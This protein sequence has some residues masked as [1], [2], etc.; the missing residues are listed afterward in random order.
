MKLLKFNDRFDTVDKI[1]GKYLP[2]RNGWTIDVL[3]NETTII[4]N[5]IESYP[6]IGQ[7][8]TK[9]HL[10]VDTHLGKKDVILLFRKR[11]NTLAILI[12]YDSLYD[13]VYKRYKKR[14]IGDRIK[15]KKKEIP[16]HLQYIYTYIYDT[17]DYLVDKNCAI[18]TDE[19]PINR[20]TVNKFLSL[21]GKNIIIDYSGIPRNIDDIHHIPRDDI[22]NCFSVH[23]AEF[24]IGDISVLWTN[25]YPYGNDI[26]MTMDMNNIETVLQTI[27]TELFDH[28][29]IDEKIDVYT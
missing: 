2:Y 24:N 13:D 18:L 10:N 8:V 26:F 12:E 7:E 23:T 5:E 27:E 11:T 19:I 29:S 20:D 14:S 15:R 4:S 16:L 17:L 1:T 6:F 25:D 28:S 22:M 3:N 21:R 9:I